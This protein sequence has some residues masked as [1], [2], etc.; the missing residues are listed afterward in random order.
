MSVWLSRRRF[1]RVTGLGFLGAVGTSLLAACGQSA[2]PSPTA[3]AAAAQPTAA[4]K[5]TTAPAAEAKPTAAASPAA[6]SAPTA[7]QAAQAAPVAKPKSGASL[8]ILVWSH[9]VPAY[10]QW[11]DDYAKSWG[12]KNGVTVAVD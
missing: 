6:A 9:F 8:K 5:P 4:P 1:V 12:S 2:A 10:D 11:L 7:A 3:P